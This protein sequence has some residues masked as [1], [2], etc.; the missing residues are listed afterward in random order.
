MLLF[1]GLLGCGFFFVVVVFLSLCLVF[2]LWGFGG[3]V[4]WFVCLDFF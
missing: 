3:G 4:G 2:L 1:F